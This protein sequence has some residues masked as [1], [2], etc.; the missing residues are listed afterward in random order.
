MR[1][2]GSFAVV[3]LACGV[4][5]GLAVAQ[6]AAPAASGATIRATVSEVLLDVDVRDSRGRVV[7]NLQPGDVEVYEDGVKR[8]L[9]S[10]RL[11]TGREARQSP[12]RSDAY[13]LPVTNSVCIVFHNLDQRTRKF[14]VEA[15]QEFLRSELRP[16]TFAAVFNLGAR[17]TLL[18]PFSNNRAELL[19]ASNQA[20]SGR[21]VD[22]A[23]DATAGLSASPLQ[24]SVEGAGM[25]SNGTLAVRGGDL[26]GSAIAGADVSSG[27]GADIAR[28]DLVGQRQ[29]FLGA[30]GRRQLDQMLMM[31]QQLGRVPGRKTVLLLSP[32][33]TLTG[34]PDELKN[35]TSSANRANISIY[36][37]DANGMTQNTATLAS[38]NLLR[39]AADVSSTQRQD[40]SST[41]TSLQMAREQSRQL[42]SVQDAART[43]NTQAGL[44]AL[45]DGTGGFLVA[46]NDLRKP[47]ARIADE[48]DVRYEVTYQPTS[49]KLDGRVRRIEVKLTRPE[50]NVRSR[51][52]Y[53]AMPDLDGS[54]LKPFEMAALE[55]LSA[56]PQPRA[57]DYRSGG[58]RFRPVD[59][60][61]QCAV[62]FEV[63]AASL[64]ATPV[65][66]QK[67]HRLHAS[68]VALVKDSGG[69]VVAKVSQDFATE[70]PDD[71][72]AVVQTN[73]LS[74]TRSIKLPPGR[75]TVETAVLDQEGKKSSTGMF[76]LDNPEQKGLG[77]SDIV[78]VQRIEPLSGK[79][80]ASDPFQF[81]G[82]R[83][84][85]QMT[86]TRPAN[87]QPYLYFVVYPDKS[88]TD[89]PEVTVQL[90]VDGRAVAEQTADLPAPDSSGAI[91]VVIGALAKPG[92]C[93]LK[94]TA[95]QGDDSVEQTVK[96]TL[97]AN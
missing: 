12:A 41:G 81:E 4:F 58:F 53:Y 21:S 34:D 96:Y 62:A 30:E 2:I 55:A 91:P 28:A 26:S 52:G 75:Y 29:A 79:P 47:L 57:F 71:Q 40:V 1:K 27:R 77:L 32:G 65:P 48:M 5:G 94:V 33:L 11:V 36:A 16:D 44:R 60:G 59:A 9:Q 17:L 76:A 63:P 93:E 64:T 89:K 74:L 15:A 45:S 49:Q 39:Q 61:S 86:S 31:V 20:F 37:I 97:A 51:T 95:S 7:K 24:V 70:I 19:Q 90:L 46:T 23:S 22:F 88:R 8:P 42:D 56:T 54:P 3:F 84:I 10:L 67:K 69:A 13:R 68:L 87:M 38:S 35:L 50:L 72:L 92:H 25:T 78:L 66:E 80:D 83:V 73:T 18:H 82:R 6:T 85:P 43:S 14:A